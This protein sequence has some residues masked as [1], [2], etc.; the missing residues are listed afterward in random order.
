[1]EGNTWLVV[2]GVGGSLLLAFVISKLLRGEKKS[3]P[4]GP[5]G[6]FLVGNVA[7]IDPAAPYKTL[8]DWIKVRGQTKN[9]FLS[10]IHYTI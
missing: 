4:P 3:Y 2:G 8:T 9:G 10:S 5:K 1:M 6:S 7:Q